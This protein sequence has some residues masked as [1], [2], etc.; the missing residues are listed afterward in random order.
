MSDDI[1]TYDVNIVTHKLLNSE[2]AIMFVN[3]KAV[4]VAKKYIIKDIN[5]SF[6]YWQFTFT[7]DG[8]RDPP[9][10]KTACTLEQ[11]TANLQN[12]LNRLIPIKFL[13]QSSTTQ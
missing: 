8:E 13:N 2:V 5:G 12:L 6:E 1:S 9:H 4:G 3:D 7:E 10:G 11:L